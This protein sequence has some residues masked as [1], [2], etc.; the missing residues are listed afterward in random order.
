[1]A[2]KTDT[3]TG[4]VIT[5]YK[6]FDSNWQCRGFQFK[7]GESFTHDGEVAACSG[8]FHACEDP[9]NV[10]AYYPPNR[11]KY[12]IVEQSGKLSREDGDTKVASEHIAIKAE[13]SITNLIKAAIKFRMDRCT[14]VGG[15]V[16]DKDSTAV[17]AQGKHEAATASGDYGAATA[18]G[19]SG[20]ATASGYYGAATASGYSGAATASGYSGAA[21]AS[22]DYGA[23]TASG[24]N[25]RAQ[26]KYGC[27]IFLVRRD[28]NRKITH[29]FAGIVGQDGIKPDVFYTL[30]EDGKPVEVEQ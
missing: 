1:M 14:T 4:E 26:G 19:Y 18:S 29:V 28:S 24:R 23:A 2:K 20:A 30:G 22:G 7:V 13:I 9:L 12:A 11:S 17:S 8:G 21:T 25:G 3:G 5:S 16:S 6:G 10:L 27:A 15:A